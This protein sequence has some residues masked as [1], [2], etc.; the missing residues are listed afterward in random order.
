[1][2]RIEECCFMCDADILPSKEEK[3][4][5]PPMFLCIKVGKP[6][7]KSFASHTTAMVQQYGKRR[8]QPEYWFA[9]PRERWA[10]AGAVST[11]SIPVACGSV[12]SEIPILV[13][14]KSFFLI[15]GFF[16]PLLEGYTPVFFWMVILTQH[17]WGHCRYNMLIR[18]H[19]FLP[20]WFSNEGRKRS[21]TLKYLKLEMPFWW[22]SR[23]GWS[24]SNLLKCS[25]E[26]GLMVF[27]TVLQCVRAEDSRAL[28]RD[29]CDSAAWEIWHE[30][31]RVDSGLH[32]FEDI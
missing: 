1:M 17:R 4:K 22:E 23:S 31:S 6:M 14:N 32:A 15:I 16:P 10:G 2:V 7:R 29:C 24:S 3:S 9:V 27:F 21:I 26:T 18:S 19:D 5:T 25:K 12:I 13:L 20:S 28:G 30:V 8:K 11:T